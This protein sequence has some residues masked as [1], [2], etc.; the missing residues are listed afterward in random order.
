M[1]DDMFQR[2]QL[3][4]VQAA[5]AIADPDDGIRDKRKAA[6]LTLRLLEA[7]EELRELQKAKEKQWPP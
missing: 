2:L 5:K 1:T 3:L 4:L 6:Q 7:G